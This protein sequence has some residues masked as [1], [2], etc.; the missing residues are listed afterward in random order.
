MSRALFLD[1]DGVL[2]QRIPDGYV[3]HEEQFVVLPGVLEALARLSPLFDHVFMVTNQ[4]GIG[5]GLM[6]EEDLRRIHAAFVGQVQAAG[7]R[8]DAIYFC[9]ALKSAHSF[10]RKPSIGMALQ[11][12]REHP[13]LCLK[14]SVMVGDTLSDMLFGRRAGMT[15][16]LVGDD[17]Q[18]AHASPHLVDYCYGD[19]LAFANAY[20]PSSP[21]GRVP[22]KK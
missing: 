5:K 1:R 8:L 2:N 21:Q 6:T 18:L 14:H 7:G 20:S 13:G 10:M 22:K 15:T 16:V 3:L 12:R 11:A 19:L 4:Q 9:P 17:P